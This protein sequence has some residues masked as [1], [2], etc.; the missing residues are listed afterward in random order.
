MEEARKEAAGSPFGAF[1]LITVGLILLLNNF[2]VLPWSIWN[3]IWRFWPVVIIIAGLENIFGRFLI[4][5]FLLGLIS[6]FVVL[7]IFFYALWGVKRES[8]YR[9]FNSPFGNRLFQDFRFSP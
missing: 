9:R 8:D 2:G 4:G 5:R 7:A 6:F 1:L 3:I